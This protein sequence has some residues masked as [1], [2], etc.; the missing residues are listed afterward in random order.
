MRAAAE[1]AAKM[2]SAKVVGYG[3]DIRG[4]LQDWIEQQ[5]LSELEPA[6]PDEPEIDSNFDGLDPRCPKC[7]GYGKFGGECCVV[8]DGTGMQQAAEP[9]EPLTPEKTLV[10]HWTEPLTETET[11]RN[12][13]DQDRWELVLTILRRGLNPSAELVRLIDKLETLLT[14]EKDGE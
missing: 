6:K 2:I 8:C 12:T 11:I 4:S 7:R 3:G 9:K 14:A 10:P 5:I 13:P 1:R